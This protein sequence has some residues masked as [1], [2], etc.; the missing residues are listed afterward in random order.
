MK[1]L[2][3]FFIALPFIYFVQAQN[4]GIGTTTPAAKLTVNGTGNNA[5]IPGPASTGVLRIGISSNEGIDIGKMP[6]GSFAGWIQSGFNG[7]IADPLVLQP[8]G[9]AVGIGT[10]NP[11]AS[12]VLDITST[13][14][15]FL[16]PRMTIAQ[17]SAI[18]GPV[19]GL[20]IWC[21]DCNQL[22][23]YDGTVW[24]NIAGP[25]A[26]L[27][28]TNI[29]SQVWTN[30]NLD[31]AMYSNGDPIP[32]VTDNTAWAALTTGAYCY[33]NNDSVTY[34]AT[35][36]KLY[37]GYA[38]HDPR[39]LAPAGWHI[40]NNAEWTTLQ[41]C[42]GGSSVAGGAMKETGTTHW[43]SP[44]TAATN[45]S[46][47]TGLPDGW[48]FVGTGAF[49]YIGLYGY[50]WSSTQ[51][52]TTSSSLIQLFYDAGNISILGGTQMTYGFSVRCVRN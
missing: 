4:V 31:V 49:Q 38:I 41:T 27:P 39:G 48:R 24:Q 47:F 14:Q 22:Q 36:G 34:A 33:Y 1:K 40:P 15:G 51:T 17:R 35:Y 44:N 13:T 21:L 11:N 52:N 3:F 32:K 46:G 43:T 30:K 28:S 20:M 18:S 45:S 7:T 37:N 42:L 9:G 29:C 26:E 19:A 50:Y 5:S 25:K 6:S 16:P 8:Q 12:A 23:V 2:L 10:T